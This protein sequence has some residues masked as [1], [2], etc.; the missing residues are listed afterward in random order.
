MAEWSPPNGAADL[1]TKRRLIRIRQR[2]VAE[3]ALASP[4]K[5]GSASGGKANTRLR[6]VGRYPRLYLIWFEKEFR[7]DGRVVEC[8]RLESE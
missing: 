1:P 3:N 8:A 5:G 2:F 7:R 4:A 6:L